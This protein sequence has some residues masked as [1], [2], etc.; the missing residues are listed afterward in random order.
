MKRF[1]YQRTKHLS[2]SE[3]LSDDDKVLSNEDIFKNKNVVVSIKEDGENTSIYDDTSHARS[4][5]SSNDSEDRNWIELF[6]M[7][8]IHKK[9]P[10]G[11][12]LCGENLF[13]KHTIK[14]EG[15]KSYFHL[16]SIWDNDVCLS[17]RDTMK[18][19]NEL[20]IQTVPII[21][22]GVYDKDI[23]KNKFDEYNKGVPSEGFVV[24][25]EDSFNIE[26]FG[27]SIAKYVSK[28]FVIPNQ[29]W[30]H[31]AKERNGSVHVNHWFIE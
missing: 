14:Y 26:D 1:K 6:R 17:W 21:Y 3:K 4:L 27:V 12:R 28:S 5:N 8:K 9:I 16:F 2:Y 10:D 15:L 7:L 25:L 13:Y 31:S 20:Q 24:R 11:Y 18:L 22:Q 30:R 19:A 29:H 23:I